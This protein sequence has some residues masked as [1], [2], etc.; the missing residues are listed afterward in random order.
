LRQTHFSESNLFGLIDRL[1]DE[2]REAQPREVRRWGLEPRG[3][4]YQSEIDWMKSWLSQRMDFIDQQLVQPPRLSHAGGQI[5]SG[6]Q[7][8]LTGPANAT[9]YYTLDGSDPRLAQGA[10]SSNAVIYAGPILLQSDARV[11]ARARNPR[12]RQTG[13]PPTS[14][15]WS[16][17][18]TANFTITR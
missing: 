5:A 2:V 17:P 14:T 6:L 1:A 11:V 9:L 10:I 8:T 16:S 18:V 4:G 15:P 7:L 12:Q 3:G 13:G